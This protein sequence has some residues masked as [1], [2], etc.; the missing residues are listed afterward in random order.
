MVSEAT[1]KGLVRD[2]I[3]SISGYP[4]SQNKMQDGVIWYAE[5]SYKGT[6][7]EWLINCFQKASK[8]QSY[9]EKGIPDFTI[10][11]EDSGCIAV[12][13]CKPETKDQNRFDDALD[14][15]GKGYGNS[16]ETQKYAVDGALW[17]ASFL[18]DKFDV[19]AIGISGQ[20]E[21]DFRI[22]SFIVPKGC[23]DK[24]VILLEDKGYQD[25]L[26]SI[27]DYEKDIDIALNRFAETREDITR[28]LRAYTLQCAN[29]LR[30]NGIEDNSK[31][32]FISA[33]LLG[34]TNKS[35]ELYRYTKKAVE[36]KK[37]S[38]VN[39]IQD[40]LLEKSARRLLKEAL[41]GKGHIG[42]DDYIEGIW[43]IDEIPLGKRNSLNKFY[44]TLL[45][46]TELSYF[47][48]G[49]NRFFNE[50]KTFLSVCIY[51]LYQNVIVI[52]EHY[53][54]I[55][56]MGEF[57]TTFLRY[58]KGNAKEKGIVLTPKH[59]T[60]L[61]CDLAEHFGKTKLTEKTKI[62]DICTGTGAFL[63]SALERIKFNIGLEALSNEKKEERCEFARK[64]SLIGVESDD[65]MFALA[66]ANM[67]FHGDGKSNLFNCSSLTRDSYFSKDERG[68][69]YYLSNTK[70]T[71]A[72]A[73]KKFDDIDFGFMN[74]PYALKD[75]A[76]ENEKRYDIS[77][78]PESMEDERKRELLIQRGQSE[79]D[80]V[81]SMLHYLKKGGIGIAIVPMSCAGN[82]GMKLRKKIMES[83]TLLAVLTMPPR[84]F[85]D[86]HVGTSTCIMVFKAHVSHNPSDPV[87]FGLWKE[88]GFKIVPHNGRKDTGN[89]K[90]IQKKLLLQLKPGH[91]P[92]NKRY[93]W[94]EIQLTDDALAEAYTE[95]DYS[96]LKEQDFR[97]TLKRYALYKYMDERGMLE[98]E[99][100]TN[101]SWF[102]E[103]VDQDDFQKLY[104]QVNTP[105]NVN[106][107]PYDPES[108]H[109]F[110]V[111]G[112]EGL[113]DVKPGVRLTKS[114]QKPGPT[115]FL[116]ATKYNNGITGYIS[117]DPVYYGPCITVNYNGSVAEAYFQAGGF[118]NSDD[119]KAWMP[120]FDLNVYKAMFIITIIQLQKQHYIY[121]RKWNG[122]AM[123]S[124]ELKLPFVYNERGEK[125]PDWEYMECFIKSLPYSG[126]IE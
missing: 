91:K 35:S 95:T 13:E 69:T 108:W 88:D 36:D 55:D 41:Y 112:E 59:I 1:T 58:T 113:F 102:L 34:L 37:A 27:E 68:K 116:G 107:R 50:G 22:T 118:F 105:K 84:L 63:I 43:D 56:I 100:C 90:Q 99:D 86:S 111:G 2:K 45:N 71:L 33:I 126:N 30:A 25:G 53:K 23:E 101:L 117:E 120:R 114:D 10:V 12:I 15:I 4:D 26:V 31:A 97:H 123:E 16:A 42:D 76:K 72:N 94:K 52:L 74:P 80:F 104:E 60:T 51:S 57:Y 65:S 106:F 110:S 38:K 19:I 39:M 32:G 121:D 20:N 81:A 66:Y 83:H 24:D 28:R 85:Y 5:E 6:K 17:Y 61:F 93:V 109:E 48:Q 9:A 98:D 125:I 64:N 75:D 89:W 67:R 14:Y 87:F 122:G 44:D 96:S 47:P 115:P 18:K 54:G 11:K 21:I 40:D 3:K 82:K 8:K 7:D 79:L 119:V 73:L 70:I 77:L 124:T 103:H 78:L 62:L 49:M 29:F 92:D 46:K